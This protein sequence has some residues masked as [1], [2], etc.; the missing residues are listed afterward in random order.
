MPQFNCNTCWTSLGANGTPDN[1]IKEGLKQPENIKVSFKEGA[2]EIK[3]P[4]VPTQAQFGAECFVTYT[5]HNFKSKI[6]TQLLAEQKDNSPSL[7]NLMGQWFQ[8]VGLTKWTSV[9]AK[10]CP[11]DADRTKATLTN[12]SRITSRLLPGFPM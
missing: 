2:K 8:D 7:F 9:I 5:L 12:V 6:L 11:D 4:V 10:K 3:G 1:L